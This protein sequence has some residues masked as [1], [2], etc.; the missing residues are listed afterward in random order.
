[1][2]LSKRANNVKPSATLAISGKAKQM[3]ADGIDVIN[4]SAGE[5]DFD[6]PKRICDAAHAAIDKGQTRYT[7]TPGILE[8]R[9]AICKACERDYGFAPH[10][11]QVVVSCG[12]KH[13]LY[14]AMQALLDPGDEA[15]IPAPYWVSY[16]PQVELCDAVPVIVPT[17]ASSSFKLTPATLR[18]AISPRTKLLILNSPSNPTGQVYSAAELK[19]LGEVIRETGITVICDD[20]YEKLIYDGQRFA[21]L[22]SIDETLRGQCVIVNGVS[23]SAAMTG[24]RIGYLIAPLTVAKAI[25][26]MQGQM[27]SNA[28][29]IAQYAALEAIAGEAVELADWRSQFEA[30]RNHIVAL[31]NEVPGVTCATPGGAFYAFA[32]FNAL[33]TRRFG[34]TLLDTDMAWADYL[35]DTAHVAS[36]PGSAFGADGF[37]RFSFATSMDRITDGLARLKAAVESTH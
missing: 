8:L 13:S 18:A 29:S 7:L 28:T 5:P 21:S 26:R 3:R 4:L 36:V 23:K 9:Q 17:D 15:L 10:P 22:A 14:L 25:S 30:R 24:W 37:L 6:T 11:D 33:L 32:D 27:T 31:L 20:I 34:D 1:M 16:P 19:A 2:K 35:L 12:A